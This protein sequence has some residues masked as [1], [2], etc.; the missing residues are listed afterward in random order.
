MRWYELFCHS[1]LITGSIIYRRFLNGDLYANRQ[2]NRV[3]SL[4]TQKVYGVIDRQLF[5]FALKECNILV[6]C[7]VPLLA[8]TGRPPSN[9]ALSYDFNLITLSPVESLS[10]SETVY[11]TYVL[12]AFNFI[13]S[14]LGFL[15]N[16]ADMSLRPKT[17]AKNS[18]WSAAVSLIAVAN[19][20]QIK[21]I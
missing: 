16:T 19:R 4:H 15:I 13:D 8:D 5:I 1:I 9:H 10:R 2:I 17:T 6:S 12:T 14:V 21:R 11:T 18:L 20:Q 7:T 3:C